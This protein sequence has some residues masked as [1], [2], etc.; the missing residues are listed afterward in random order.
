MHSN[1][2]TSTKLCPKCTETKPATTEYF[3][4]NKASKDGLQRHC[5]S[6][7]RAYH[8]ANREQALEGMRAYREANHEKVLE[9]KRVH[10]FANRDRIR[11]E[12]AAYRKANRK[13]LVKYFRD[14]Y[15]A[16]RDRRGE[17]RR[18]YVEANRDRVRQA[19]RSYNDRNKKSIAE[20]KRAWNTANPEA[21]KAAMQ[22][23]RAHKLSAE[24]THTTADIKAQY[25]RQ[26][27]R[28]YYC[29]A[30]L[31]GSYHADHIVPLSRGGNNW[32]ENIVC[33]CASC[34]TSK[35]DKFLHE[36]QRGGRLL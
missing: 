23:R 28:C 21:K 26:K 17:Q 20:Y 22:R 14:H 12:H 34:N 25:E 5:K 33:A 2:T 30:K 36:W 8:A 32:P 24:G 4:R 10:Y 27:G 31:N 18:A 3:A 9:Q 11:E 6:C 35:G 29:D 15:A 16:N 1:Y 19:Q 7:K 13:H